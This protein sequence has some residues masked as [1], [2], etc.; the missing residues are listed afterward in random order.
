MVDVPGQIFLH[1]EFAS[2]NFLTNASILEQHV[3]VVPGVQDVDP[4]RTCPIAW[5]QHGWS[6]PI[7]KLPQIFLGGD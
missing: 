3:H 2:V 6:M 4:E 7:N 1:D 5:L